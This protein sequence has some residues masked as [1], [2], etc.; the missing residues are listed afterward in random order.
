MASDAASRPLPASLDLSG[1]VALVTG[2][3]R[4]IGRAISLLLAERGAKVVVNYAKGEAAAREVAAA[5][6]ASGGAAFVAGFDVGDE[7]AVDAAI[8][9]LV[10]AHGGLDILVNNAGVSI[11]A[12]M[13]RARAEDFDTLI[14]TN[15]R[16][17][18]LC[19]KAATR[20]LLRAKDKGRIVNL[21]SVVGEQGNIGQAMYA[22]TKA[23]VIGMTKSLARELASRAVTV[24]AVAPGF[25][26]TDMT[27][28]ALQGDART[29]LLAQIPLGRVG[30][31]REVAEAVAYL[32]SPAASYITGH[33]LRI[34]GGLLI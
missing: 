16:G 17:T 24:N 2:G 25:I 20:H 34:N 14:R 33:V 10:E 9:Q 13:M 19:S 23:G 18:F 6:E 5:I 4:G 3:G 8:K 7:A 15:L 28:A 29:A 30:D 12:L 22:A 31:P 26:D 21:T 1:R 32:A 11:D 27:Q